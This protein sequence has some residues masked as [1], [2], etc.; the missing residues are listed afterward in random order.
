MPSEPVSGW[1][2]QWRGING[3]D[4]AVVLNDELYREMLFGHPLHR[5]A[6]VALAR[7]DDSDDVLFLASDGRVAQAHL[8]WAER[9]PSWPTVV[10]HATLDDWATAQI[11]E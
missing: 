1:P 10:F 9:E 6:P 11:E 7:R 5:L 8:T 2:P 4:E 3:T